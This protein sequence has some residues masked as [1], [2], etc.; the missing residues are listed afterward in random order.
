MEYYIIC[1]TGEESIRFVDEYWLDED[2]NMMFTTSG[3]FNWARSFEDYDYACEIANQIYNKRVTAPNKFEKKMFNT[4]KGKASFI[5]L[6]KAYF[7]G[8]GQQY[9]VTVVSP[10]ELLDAKIHPENHRNLIVRVGGY[11][12]YFVN[13]G[14]ELQNNVI[15][16]TLLES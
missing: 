14:E 5:A 4:E 2:G 8:G 7:A 15:E 9:T 10:E 1:R 16:R 3:S 12:D 6:A 11:S 13:I